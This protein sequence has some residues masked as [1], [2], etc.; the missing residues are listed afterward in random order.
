M[1]WSVARGNLT[2]EI[3]VSSFA[4]LAFAPESRLAK[5]VIR[6]WFWFA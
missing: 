1:S 4:Y 6:D 2:I 3:E 5:N